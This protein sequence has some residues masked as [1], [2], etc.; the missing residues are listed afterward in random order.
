[1]DLSATLAQVNR[2][3]VDDRIRLVQAIWDSITAF[4]KFV[5]YSGGGGGGGGGGPKK[6]L[7]LYLTNCTS[8]RWNL[9]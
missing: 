7:T 5:R 1:M 8:R 3:S 6:S 4:F 9:L 2:L